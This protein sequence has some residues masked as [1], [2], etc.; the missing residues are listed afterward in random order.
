MVMDNKNIVLLGGYGNFGKRITE[1]LLDL[2]NVTLYI[3]GRNE[4][5]ANE[6]CTQLQ[7]KKPAPPLLPVRLDINAEDFESKLRQLNPFLVIHTGGPFQGQDYKVPQLCI[8]VGCHYID[9][10]DDRRF[11]CDINKLDQAAKEKKLLI[12]S[13]ASSV[14][15]LSSTVVDHYL[16]RFKE[17]T[18]IDFAISPGNKAERGEATV[19]AILSYT[20]HPF[21]VLRDKRWIDVIGWGESKQREFGGSIGTRWLANIDIPDLELFPTRYPTTKNVHFQAGLEVAI[22]H[23]GMSIM[24]K[25]TRLNI[26]KCWSPL[27]KFIVKASELFLPFGSDNGGMIVALN[28]L[29][30]ESN[31]LQVDWTLYANDG[32][33][34]YIPTIS[35]IILARKLIMGEINDT[36]AMPCQGMYS[37]EEFDECAKTWG[38]YH[39]EVISQP[40]DKR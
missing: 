33:G 6:L 14:P 28:G 7:E 20:G 15:G 12:V 5:K 22:L 40:R 39:S 27:T 23:H 4:Q 8:N 38:I 25:L 24:S 32:V 19:R 34:P 18:T 26:V 11:V 2:T 17:L 35:T 21:K 31:P 10:A 3:A 16:P 30:H 29:D 13:G 1:S 37:L 9:L 36:G